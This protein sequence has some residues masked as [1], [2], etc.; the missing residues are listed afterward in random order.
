MPGSKYDF[1]SGTSMAAPVVAGMAAMIRG[2]YPELT[3]RQVRDVIR[4]SVQAVDG[5]VNRP[6]SK[7]RVAFTT[8]SATNGIVNLEA[9]F[10]VIEK[11]D[12][13]QEP[14]FND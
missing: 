10:Q 3:A 5:K 8:L 1:N 11:L 14:L 4:R 13:L 7:K 12:F 6:G 2:M 9:C